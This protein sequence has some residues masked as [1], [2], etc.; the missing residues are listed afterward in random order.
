MRKATVLTIAIL[1]VTMALLACDVTYDAQIKENASHSI[2][3]TPSDEEIQD[4]CKTLE[5]NGWDYSTAS[6]NTLMSNP[7]AGS[8]VTIMAAITTIAGGDTADYCQ[9][10]LNE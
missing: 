2:G 9:G 1:L 5:R 10:K 8:K 4:A 3:R 6:M 7:A